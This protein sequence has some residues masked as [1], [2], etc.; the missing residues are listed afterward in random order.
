MLV[1]RALN[2][3]V[4]EYESPGAVEERVFEAA[5]PEGVL[6]MLAIEHV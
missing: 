4:L 3:H 1:E 5:G 6:V 2:E